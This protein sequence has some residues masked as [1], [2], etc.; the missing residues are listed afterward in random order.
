MPSFS[1]GGGAS[2]G[3]SS[4][5]QVNS[6]G[7]GVA[8][9]GTAG[10]ATINALTTATGGVKVPNN[11]AIQSVNTSAV[12]KKLIVWSNTDEVIIGDGTCA[13]IDMSARIYGQD[14]HAIQNFTFLQLDPVAFASIP[15]AANFEGS[16]IPINNSNT[17]VWGATIA[18]G[19]TNH[20][21]GYYDGT[22]WTVMAK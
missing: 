19:G 17:N 18:G 6:L 13:S 10:D 16:I 12:V 5:L 15:A 14:T 1:G 8:A 4:N 21:L 22:A 11:V 20:V 2:V 9:D 3:P 7:V